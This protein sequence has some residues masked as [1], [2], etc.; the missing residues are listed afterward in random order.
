MTEPMDNMVRL[1]LTVGDSGG[2]I[3]SG[4]YVKLEA[5]GTVE[6]LEAL[7]V[8]R[9]I[10]LAVAFG[11]HQLLKSATPAPTSPRRARSGPVQVPPAS[12]DVTSAQVARE[13]RASPA[14][15]FGGAATIVAGV[16]DDRPAEGLTPLPP[17]EGDREDGGP[18]PGA[19]PV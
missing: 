9:I 18:N 8:T 17:V 5:V 10:E 4:P 6:S 1:A 7:G 15:S 16:P 14:P 2:L 12:L 19:K 3:T 13:R 11:N